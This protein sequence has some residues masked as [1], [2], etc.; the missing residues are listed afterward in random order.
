MHLGISVL[1]FQDEQRSSWSGSGSRPIMSHIF[2]P[3]V[4]DRE[5]LILLGAPGKELFRAGDAAWN[6]KPIDG[7]RFPLVIMSH[8]TGGSALQLLWFAKALVKNGYIV[9]GLNHHGN[10]AAE[11]TKYAEGFMLWWERAQDINVALDS[12]L[13]NKKFSGLIDADKIAVAGFSLGGYTALATLGGLTDV[14]RFDSFC[15]SKKRDA[16]CGAQIEFP[17]MLEDFAKVKD[18][19]P[20]QASLAREKLD[21]K[22]KQIKAAFVM[23][24]A[25][26][27]A[28]TEESMRGILLPVSVVVGDGDNVAPA[29]TNALYA[30]SAI[31]NS[32]YNVLPKVGHYTFLSE[33]TKLGKRFLKDLCEDHKGEVHENVGAKAVSFFDSVFK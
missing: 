10:T 20:V 29:S 26:V 11:E 7:K 4:D 3:A 22:N 2:Y 18:S 5:E 9:L 1:E 12:L 16:T 31:K 28:L 32:G 14:A 25:A 27:Q 19:A 6:A 21:Y 13:K 23:A 30:H 15:A 24:P 33:C 8:G 17:T